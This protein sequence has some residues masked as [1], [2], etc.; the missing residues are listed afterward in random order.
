LTSCDVVPAPYIKPTMVN[1]EGSS[2]ELERK[3]E[4]FWRRVDREG[5]TPPHAPELGP[6]WIWTGGKL[7]KGY[8]SFRGLGQKTTGAHR[9]A[10]L[11][12]HEQIP[13]GMHVL[14]RC[15]N[16]ACVRVSHLFLGTNHENVLDM[17]AKG[18][19]GFGPNLN[20]ASQ[21]G[22]RNHM[23]KLTQ[24]QVADARS[25]YAAGG[26]THQQLATELGISRPRM[27][28]ILNGDGWAGLTA[29][30]PCEATEPAR[31]ARSR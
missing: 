19:H 6:C 27:T 23:S 13:S 1:A 8:G 15:D 7:G 4:L 17:V 11:E 24:A 16:R 5:P 14:H 29:P 18:R 21:H 9:F 2:V 12:A 3:R 28:M 30:C 31:A 10:W 22:E 20:T 25:R 26:V